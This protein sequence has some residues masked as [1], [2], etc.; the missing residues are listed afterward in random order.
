MTVSIEPSEILNAQGA[1]ALLDALIS[2]RGSDVAIDCSNVRHLGAQA[3][4]VLISAQKTWGDEGHG[5][6]I[7]GASEA[8]EAGFAAL[9]ASEIFAQEAQA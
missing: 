2:A 1:Q 9:G 6:A 5:F 8:C 3:L 7:L 4:Q